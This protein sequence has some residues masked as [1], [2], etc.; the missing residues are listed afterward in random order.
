MTEEVKNLSFRSPAHSSS[1]VHCS[2]H[3]PSTRQHKIFKW[4]QFQGVVINPLFQLFCV[5][6][7]ESYS[8]EMCRSC[9][10]HG[11]SHTAANVLGKFLQGLLT[12]GCSKTCRRHWTLSSWS[13]ISASR[14]FDLPN[15]RARPTC[16]FDNILDWTK[17]QQYLAAQLI[18]CSKGREDFIIFSPPLPCV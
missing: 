10:R 13:R 15:S 18:N 7:V 6:R 4:R 14:F 17:L 16:T 12:A 5:P 1:H 2:C 9:S 3:N 11:G 8:L